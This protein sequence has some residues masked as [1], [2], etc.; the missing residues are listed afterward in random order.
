M[1]TPL[2]RRQFLASGVLAAGAVALG[3]CAGAK[4]SGSK[5]VPPAGEMPDLG[6][7]MGVY[8]NPLFGNLHL[9]HHGAS[10]TGRARKRT[11]APSAA[12]ITRC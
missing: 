6:N 4:G 11:S 5:G 7:W 9:V 8:Y 1:T 3:G 2:N 10:A 12:A